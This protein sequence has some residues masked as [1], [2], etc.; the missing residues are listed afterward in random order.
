MEA[1]NVKKIPSLKKI[2]EILPLFIFI[3]SCVL[4]LCNQEKNIAITQA[5]IQ[6]VIDQNKIQDNKLQNIQSEIDEM[7]K[8]LINK[9][10]DQANERF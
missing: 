6:I 7:Y 10:S 3:G 8:F 4:Y 1:Y 2:L 5:Q 9:E